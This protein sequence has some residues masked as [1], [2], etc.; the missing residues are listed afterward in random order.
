MAPPLPFSPI[1]TELQHTR[2]WLSVKIDARGVLLP[3]NF[4]T[5]RALENKNSLWKLYEMTFRLAVWK[6][7]L[8]SCTL[9]SIPASRETTAV[10]D[11]VR[12]PMASSARLPENFSKSSRSTFVDCSSK[13]AVLGLLCRVSTARSDRSREARDRR[14][15]SGDS[16]SSRLRADRCEVIQCFLRTLK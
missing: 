5:R 1:R 3:N 12:F 7:E 6:R 15:K 8:L 13:I 14:G 9:I 10:P 2:H 16:R 4:G 11:N